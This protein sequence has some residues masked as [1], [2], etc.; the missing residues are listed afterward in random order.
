MTTTA[1]S[2]HIAVNG[3]MAGRLASGSG[4]Y[5]DHLLD[6]LPRIAPGVQIS[7]LLPVHP[8][9][10]AATPAAVTA[11]WPEVASVPV[12]L[13]RLPENL[14]KLWWEQVAAPRAARRA[15]A[16]I[17]W[18]PY[19][20]GPIWAPLP[21]AVTIHDLI[22]LL[23]PAYHGR[24]VQRAYTRLVAWSARRAAAIL[25]VSEAAARD[26][27]TH[28]DVAPARV[29]VVY[30]GPNQEGAAPP[31]TVDLARVRHRYTLPERFFLY[32]GG[33]DVRKNLAG[34]IGGY[35][36]YLERGG[37]PAV[38]LVLAGALPSADTAFFPD[39][40]RLAREAGCADQVRFCGWVE[41]AD[42]PALYALATAFIFPSL[43]EGFGMMVLEAMQAG[44]PVVTS[45]NQE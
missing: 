27:V 24:L 28:L 34:I 41:E 14:A 12:R 42:K 37:D 39:P 2:L 17:Y 30:H 13:P 35:A 6:W 5:L 1:H 10:E 3:W 18:A 22:P 33:F 36:R 7:L 4:Q 19:W 45:Q 8:A 26:I 29:H 15:H 21:V 9:L 16:G 20:A 38:K 43:Y 23:L 44:T 11:R 31:T 32:L 25:T 40:R